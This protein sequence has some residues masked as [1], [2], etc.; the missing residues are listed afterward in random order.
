MGVYQK[1]LG[2]DFERLGLALKQ[3]HDEPKRVTGCLTVTHSQQLVPK[4][5]VWLMRLPKAGVDLETTL[6][7]DVDESLEKWEREI[8]SVKLVT[9]QYSRNGKLVESAG[10]INFVFDLAEESGAMV[11]HHYRSEFFGVPM[12]KHIAP[13]IDARVDPDE[14]GWMVCVNIQCPRYGTICK[15]E[16]RINTV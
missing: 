7:V 10:P 5:F 14:S 3:F 16:G 2:S 15:Y 1:I 8:G 4:F 6:V 9:R 12:P 13:I 11:F